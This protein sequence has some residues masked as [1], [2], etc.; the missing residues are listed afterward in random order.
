M[1]EIKFRAWNGDYF[2]LSEFNFRTGCLGCNFSSYVEL[3][4]P[5]QFTGLKDKNGVDIYEGDIVSDGL[6]QDNHCLQGVFEVKFKGGGFYP[7]CI[8]GWECTMFTGDCEVIGNIY[9]NP[10]LLESK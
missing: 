6:S 9:E 3:D 4:A 8:S 10:E 7:F 5:Q 2:E 1:R